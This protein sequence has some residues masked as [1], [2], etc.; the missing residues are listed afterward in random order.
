M[1]TTSGETELEHFI[2][3]LAKRVKDLGVIWVPA[4]IFTEAS[5]P[6]LNAMIDGVVEE[7]WYFDFIHPEHMDSL[8][9]RAANLLRFTTICVSYIIMKKNSQS[10]KQK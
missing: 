10:S 7:N 1:Q 5:Y 6:T 2:K 8:P 4:L 3:S 9:V